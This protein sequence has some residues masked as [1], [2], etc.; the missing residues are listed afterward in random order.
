[1]D[2]KR[3]GERIVLFEAW[4]ENDEAA[5][6]AEEILKIKARAAARRGRRDLSHER[7]VARH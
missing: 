5:W 1:M 6:I 3:R 2:A 7:P 4:G